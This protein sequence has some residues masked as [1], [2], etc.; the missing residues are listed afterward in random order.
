MQFNQNQ[1]GKMTSSF[2]IPPHMKPA[3]EQ[4]KKSMEDREP[5]PQVPPAETPKMEP[6]KG[7]SGIVTDEADVNSEAS[8]LESPSVLEKDPLMLLKENYDIEITSEDIQRVVYKGYTEKD[9]IAVPSVMGSDPL[10]VTFKTLTGKEY[11]EADE[12]LAE[13][14]RDIKMTNEGFAARRGMWLLAYGVKKIQ[15]K[16]W[17]QTKYTDDT[18]KVIDRKATLEARKNAL[19]N[20]SP[21]VLSRMM[22]IQSS[23]TIAINYIFVNAKGEAVKKP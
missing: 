5:R 1:E 8:K 21:V 12:K 4:A 6:D 17:Y 13:E 23:L 20:F 15:G 19:N 7:F 14:G 9:V 2:G 22:D 18:K 3:L 16:P 11:E 10:V